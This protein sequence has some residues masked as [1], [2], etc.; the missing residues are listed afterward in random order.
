MQQSHPPMAERL[1]GDKKNAG[2]F[3]YDFAETDTMGK[4]I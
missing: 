3:M 4:S 1:S 2:N